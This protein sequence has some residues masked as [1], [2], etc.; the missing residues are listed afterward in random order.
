M[1]TYP[2]SSSTRVFHDHGGPGSSFMRKTVLILGT[3]LGLA[4][5]STGVFLIYL[6]GLV[7]SLPAVSITTIFT[8]VRNISGGDNRIAADLDVGVRFKNDAKKSMVF[9]HLAASASQPKLKQYDI[10]PNYLELGG[11]HEAS[12]DKTVWFGLKNVMLG[13]DSWDAVG[14]YAR[15]DDDDDNNVETG[16]GGVMHG[17]QKSGFSSVDFA[18]T[19][20]VTYGGRAWLKRRIPIR[21]ACSPL[22]IPFSSSNTTQI[23]FDV[24]DDD[25]VYIDDK[26]YYYYQDHY[27]GLPR[28][29]RWRWRWRLTRNCEAHGL[30]DRFDYVF[31]L[32]GMFLLVL[33]MFFTLALC[34]YQQRKL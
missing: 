8:T 4:M 28:R 17:I 29:G 19:S 5:I 23:N 25:I 20:N 24:F 31:E 26:Y 27:H 34:L 30:W 1:S 2:S 3:I 32:A 14:D 6:P 21:V 13:V 9:D 7:P 18:L 16:S 22:R 12:H 10:A 11:S 33:G 15:D